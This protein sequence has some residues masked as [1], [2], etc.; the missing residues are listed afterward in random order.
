MVEAA[1]G[2][3]PGDPLDPTAGFGPMVSHA[4]WRV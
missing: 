2:F 1:K 3:L 4:V